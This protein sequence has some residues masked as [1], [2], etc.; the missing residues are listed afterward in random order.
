MA[1]VLD[2]LRTLA[3]E[4]V[5]Y[6]GTVGYVLLALILLGFSPSA[7]RRVVGH[8]GHFHLACVRGLLGIR[9]VEEGRVPDGPV[10]IACRHESMFEAVDMPRLLANPGVFAKAEL[11][12]IPL[13]GKVGERFGLIGVERD[14]GA[15]ALRQM[16]SRA[17]EIS[18]QGR[19]LAI[20]PEGTRVP[21]GTRAPLQAGFAGLYKLLGL[22]VVPI[23]V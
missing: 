5:F 14:Q 4:I 20:F 21:H 8:W 22:P 3:F 18:A 7:F 23:A 2:I 10:L 19:P 17:R 12:R 16:V 1:R 13:W 11:L 9:V 6:L 15:R